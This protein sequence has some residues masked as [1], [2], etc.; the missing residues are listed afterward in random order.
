MMDDDVMDGERAHI[1]H[2]WPRH[3]QEEFVWERGPIRRSLPHFRVL[4]VA[5][6]DRRDPWV[7]ASLGAWKATTGEG[8]GTEFFL[9]SPSESPLHVEL[10]AMVANLHA[11]PRYRLSLGSVID[12]GR[13]WLEE[14]AADHLLVSLPYPYGPSLEWCDLGEQ[15][16][17]FLWLVPITTAEARL[18]R[19]EG[20]EALE[21]RLELGDVNVI[22]PKRHSLV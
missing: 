12:I 16:V 13:P 20:L 15:H 8:H 1:S 4:R 11:D 21:R 14:S 18:V 9:L 2:I 22:S 19:D 5:P 6:V 3:P 10:L 7:Y 17:R